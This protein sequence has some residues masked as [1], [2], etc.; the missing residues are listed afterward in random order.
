MTAK[1]YLR[2][3][4]IIDRKIK[5]EIEK[6]AEMRSALYGRGVSCKSD[7]SKHV[8]R[9]N[10]F[11]N[12]L[13]RVMEQEERLDAEIDQLTAKRLEIEKAIA[14]VPNEVQ[15]EVLTRRYLLY[16]KWEVIA[17]AMNYSERH[18]R[19]LHGYALKN[20]SLNVRF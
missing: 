16:Q 18:I 8:R 4:Y 19:R 14:A 2:Q 17:E 10:G 20:M 5:L 9:G 6:L 1:E 7:G 12:A 13:L 11:E 15:R 3:A